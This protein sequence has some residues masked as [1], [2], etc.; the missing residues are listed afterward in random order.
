[1]KK[2]VLLLIGFSLIFSLSGCYISRSRQSDYTKTDKLPYDEQGLY[3][4]ELTYYLGEFGSIYWDTKNNAYI[5]KPRNTL[6]EAIIGLV[7]DPLNEEYIEY[8]DYVVE[9]VKYATEI[10]PC[11]VCIANPVNA[12][13][14]IL[15]V[16]IGT[17]GYSVF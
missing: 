11:T 4:D 5:L 16:V 14:Y 7:I 2:F 17:I 15:V 3:E 10:Y 9:T 8:W 1:M 13:A 12:D 6:R